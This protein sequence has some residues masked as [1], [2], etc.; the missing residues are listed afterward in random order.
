MYVRARARARVCVCVVDEKKKREDPILFLQKNMRY[1]LSLLTYVSPESCLSS[2]Y[3]ESIW[4]V[5]I[6][7]LRC[8]I[9]MSN[10]YKSMYF[11]FF[12]TLKVAVL[13]FKSMYPYFTRHSLSDFRGS[14]LI[15]EQ[16][17]D[18]RSRNGRKSELMAVIGSARY[19][20]C[21]YVAPKWAY[22]RSHRTR[23]FFYSDLSPDI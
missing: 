12:L 18:S 14:E 9:W 4:I 5:R 3:G 20:F 1:S 19:M 22:T 11:F 8:R 16:C 2:I 7:S 23:Y 13:Q 15:E 6:C 17:H 10:L 21:V